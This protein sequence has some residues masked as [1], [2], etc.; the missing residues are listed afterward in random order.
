MQGAVL[1]SS[2]DGRVIAS[3]SRVSDVQAPFAGAWILHPNHPESPLHL[4]A[5]KDIGY[6]AV[7]PDGTWVATGE[8]PTGP[9][10]NWDART[11]RLERQLRDPGGPIQFSP[12]GRSLIVGRDNSR[13][14]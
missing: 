4:D 3:R 1:A 14:F 2:R 11:G 6:L 8:F 10:K 13:Y 12:D 5:G 7:S 9:V